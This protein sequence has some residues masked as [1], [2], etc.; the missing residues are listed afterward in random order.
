MEWREL[1]WKIDLPGN[2]GVLGDL[3]SGDSE[4]VFGEGE[5]LRWWCPLWA[6]AAEGWWGCIS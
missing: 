5:E 4:S 2:G 1:K 6:G 3:K